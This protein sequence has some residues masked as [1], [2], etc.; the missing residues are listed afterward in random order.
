MDDHLEKLDKDEAPASKEKMS[1]L[2]I[3]NTSFKFAATLICHL[4]G[5]TVFVPIMT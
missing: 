1:N 3:V 2:V 4:T 5:D